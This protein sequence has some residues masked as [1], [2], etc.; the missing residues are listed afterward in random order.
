MTFICNTVCY[1]LPF[2]KLKPSSIWVILHLPITVL[3]LCHLHRVLQRTVEHVQTLC[4]WLV[5]PVYFQKEEKNVIK[6]V[7]FCTYLQVKALLDLLMWDRGTL[8]VWVC[9]MSSF[10]LFSCTF[11]LIF[12]CTDELYLVLQV[13]SCFIYI[14][15]IFI[16]LEP[17]HLILLG[18]GHLNVERISSWSI[19]TIS[20]DS[21]VCSPK[22]CPKTYVNVWKLS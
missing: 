19:L 8:Y 17:K 20:V 16:I 13:P 5:K 12:D 6:I 4:Q 1:Y 22:Y 7:L 11:S 14:A 18:F 15:C 9:I 3:W 2:F 21:I 10:Y